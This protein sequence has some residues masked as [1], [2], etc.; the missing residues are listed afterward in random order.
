MEVSQL[1]K[2]VPELD[3]LRL[4]IIY[5]SNFEL[6]P[7]DKATMLKSLSEERYRTIVKNLEYIDEKLVDN[8][9]NKFR[10][11]FKEYTQDQYIEYQR[12][13]SSSEFEILRS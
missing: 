6:P 1:A 4:L 5:F 9:G 7:K 2:D 3:Y 12:E 13:K 11:R 10:R 8:G